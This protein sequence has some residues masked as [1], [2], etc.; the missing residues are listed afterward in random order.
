MMKRILD[1][2]D[3]VPNEM[4]CPLTKPAA[5]TKPKYYSIT[6]KKVEWV[7]HLGYVS[8]QPGQPLGF[9]AIHA[10]IIDRDT[11]K[12]VG[13]AIGTFEPMDKSD[14]GLQRLQESI[15]EKIKKLYE[16][17]EFIQKLYQADMINNGLE[18]FYK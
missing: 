17:D 6:E 1:W 13:T 5:P 16:K 15:K 4:N 2:F 12:V 18:W 10:N 7:S 14:D 9:Y 11:N 8:P 3:K